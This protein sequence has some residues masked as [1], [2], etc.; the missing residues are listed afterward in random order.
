MT[1]TLRS[2]KARIGIIGS[3][4][5]A[6]ALGTGFLKH[7]HDV[8][9]GT[10]DPASFKHNFAPPIRSGLAGFKDIGRMMNTAFPNVVVTEEDMIAD[11]NRASSEVRRLP[12][13]RIADGR[14]GT[15]KQIH[16][17]E[18]HIYRFATVRSSNTGSR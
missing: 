3:G 7:G 4:D 13:T 8:L 12:P 2:T 17:T 6:K 10:R 15:N 9:L 16:R 14:G 1:K 18:I 5:V 11:E